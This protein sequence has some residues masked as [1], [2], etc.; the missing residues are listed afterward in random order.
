[1]NKN[2][3]NNTD[4][5]KTEKNRMFSETFVFAFLFC[6]A[7]VLLYGFLYYNSLYDQS[8]N[9]VREVL[10]GI[11]DENSA[12]FGYSHRTTPTVQF[13]I[14]GEIYK[15]PTKRF[16]SAAYDSVQPVIDELN[17]KGDVTVTYIEFEKLNLYREKSREIIGL[18][19]G[20]KEYLDPDESIKELA[21]SYKSSKNTCLVFAILVFIGSGVYFFFNIYKKKLAKAK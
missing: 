17:A 5:K 21:E 10:N 4:N 6:V 19:I 16:Q 2:D 1:M 14:N 20:D 15:A 11:I 13:S 18:K 9:G 3:I 7:L 12:E 8:N